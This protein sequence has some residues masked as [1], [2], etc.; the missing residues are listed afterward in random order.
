MRQW[1][2]V[3]AIMFVFGYSAYATDVPLGGIGTGI[4]PFSLSYP[5]Q[6]SALNWSA[7]YTNGYLWDGYLAFYTDAAGTNIIAT[8]STI[9]LPAYGCNGDCGSLSFPS[10]ISFAPNTTYYAQFVQTCCFWN[11][12]GWGVFTIGFHPSGI[13]YDNNTP[14]YNTNSVFYDTSDIPTFFGRS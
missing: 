2:V 4:T 3:V 6:F 1:V 5:I 12:G 9:Y 14:P 8:S 11:G 7:G 10:V 13:G